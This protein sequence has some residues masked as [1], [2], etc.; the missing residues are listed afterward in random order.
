MRW[1]PLVVVLAF[2]CL[3]AT[4]C[5]ARSDDTAH[6]GVSTERLATIS[7]RLKSEPRNVGLLIERADLLRAG[8]RWEEM[9]QDLDRA[10]RLD[11]RNARARGLR[12]LALGVAKEFGPALEDIDVAVDLEPTNA[13]FWGLRGNVLLH[14]TKYEDAIDSLDRSIA[15]SPDAPAYFDRAACHREMGDLAKAVDDYSAALRHDPQ[16]VSAAC[17]RAF[18]HQ[19]MGDF[20]NALGDLER[21]QIQHPHDPQLALS[22]AWILATSPDDAIRDGKRALRV[23]S[24]LCD[25]VTCETSGPLNALAAAYAEVGDFAE[26]EKLLT[27]AAA[28]APFDRSV[29]EASERRLA[30]VRRG[31]PIRDAAMP[32]TL[33]PPIAVTVPRHFGLE[34]ALSVPA[35][36]LAF[37]YLNTDTLLF[38][39]PLAKRGATITG[40]IDGFALTITSTNAESV[41][42]RLKERKEGIANAIRRRGHA[43]LAAGYIAKTEGECNAWGLDE[44]MVLV[45]QEGFDLFFTQGVTRHAG[46]V[47]ES[48]VAIR[49]DANVAVRIG[50][51]VSDGVLTFTTAQRGGLDGSAQSRCRWIL[52]PSEIDGPEWADAFCGRAIAYRS[53]DMH[54]EAVADLD[55]AM[56]LRPDAE[57][58][59]LLAF[60]LATCEDAAVRDGKRSME[61]A[62][63]GKTLSPGDPPA[64]VL[65]ALAA[66]HAE[67]GDFPQAVRYQ[68][69]VL[70]AATDD[71][72]PLQQERLRLF[73]SRKPLRLKAA[74]S[75]TAPVDD[76]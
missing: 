58:A 66:A 59:A 62:E 21:C 24:E 18:V 55:A 22:M 7:R 47:V 5:S 56:T 49:H 14:L 48:S 69:Q 1:I 35:D 2:P 74:F 28:L 67:A 6:D 54:R 43:R 4:G 45:E 17:E 9:R 53:Y 64:L 37:D 39:C 46:V 8:G 33:P 29:R 13:V 52:T 19:Q 65:M 57:T 27:R 61:L 12:A 51:N 25:P 20:A 23:A 71:D 50:G 30:A 10:I 68:R 41:E 34:D 16:L 73:E 44:G 42:S 11:P 63:R 3:A 31:E 75:E 32:P 72:K 70:R 76:D 15:L 60:I 40:V 38:S 36:M 26:A